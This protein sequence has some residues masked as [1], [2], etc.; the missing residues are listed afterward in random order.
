MDVVVHLAARMSGEASAV[1]GTAVEGTS[2]L[3][4][5]MERARVPRLVLASSLSVYDWSTGAGR[6]NEDS[7]L[8]TRP[9]SRDSYTLAKLRQEELSRESCTR[10]GIRLT[11]LRPGIL[12]GPDHSYPATIGQRLGPLHVAIGAGRQLP[13]VHVENCADAF[14]AV[15]DASNGSAGT[16]NVIDHPE[17]TVRRFVRDY[18]RES[19]DFGFMIPAPFGASLACVRGLH[20]VTPK[21]LEP[22][23]PS[24]LGPERFVARYSPVVVESGRL[25]EV[26]GW[27]P[28]LAYDECWRRTF[29]RRA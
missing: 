29:V 21:S 8:E 9:E 18:L 4:D 6:L 13:A 7:P 27:Q 23:L 12:W 22:R 5:A 16:F 2:R 25:R 15:I 1:V 3:L 10:S 11:V 19:G 26:L 14:A 28:P 17:L 20:R 24:F